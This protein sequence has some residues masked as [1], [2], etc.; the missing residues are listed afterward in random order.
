MDALLEVHLGMTFF[1]FLLAVFIGWV[2]LGRAVLIVVLG[3]QIL[4]GAVIAAWAIASHTAIPATGWLHVC[5]GSVALGAYL[6]GHR[7]VARDERRYRIV[8]WLASLCGLALIVL[9]AWYGVSLY[10]VHGV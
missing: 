10:R 8:G 2:Q 4:I 9:A 5:A 7:M 6:L 1:V 3:I